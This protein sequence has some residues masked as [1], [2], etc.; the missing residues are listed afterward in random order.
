[1]SKYKDIPKKNFV[2]LGIITLITIVL[3]FYINAWMKT[4]RDNKLSVSP[5]GELVEEVSI[6][7]IDVTFSEMNEV[8]LYVGYTKDKVLYD[9]EKKLISYIK[10]YDLV[11]KFIYVNVDEYKDNKQYIDI[12]KNVFKEVED[13]IVKAPMLIYV[14]NGKAEKVVNA[15]NGII[16]TYDVSGL[17]EVYQLNN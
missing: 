12:L 15:K 1:M 11:D 4:Y 9:S 2:I 5:L 17:N 14:R 16:S 7:E 3:T 6:N 10:K 8:I 13:D